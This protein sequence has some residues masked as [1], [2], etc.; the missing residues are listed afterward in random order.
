MSQLCNLCPRKCNVDRTKSLGFC[1]STD[2]LRVA[3]IGL[4]EWEEPCICYGNGSGTVFFSGCNMRCVYCQNYEISSYNRGKDIS[5][6]T[7]CKEILKLCDM[8][9]CNINFVTPTHYADKIAKAL[10]KIKGKLKIPVLYNSSGYES[11]EN[12]KM[13]DGLVD[14]YLPDLKYYSSD[15]SA[16]YSSCP[17]Y[18]SVAV[19]AISAM[20][21]STGKCR[22]SN[23]GA[24]LSGTLV[25]HLVLPTLYRDGILAF[26]HLAKNI[27]LNDVAVSVM[28]QYFPSHM[29][30]KYSEINRRVTTLEYMKVVECVRNLGFCRGFMQERSSATEKYVPIFDYK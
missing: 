12:I 26:E 24:L 21:K 17:D 16:K 20:V 8:G 19:R 29:A 1:K 22:F 2:T 11:V 18:F 25:R 5:V 10:E 27:N 7:L 9:A 30:S 28:S 6:E 23:D 13:L 15:V 4:H 14:I 3:R